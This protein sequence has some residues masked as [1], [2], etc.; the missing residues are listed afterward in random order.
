LIDEPVSKS[1]NSVTRGRVELKDL[2]VQRVCIGFRSVV[3]RNGG[4]TRR[5]RTSGVQEVDVQ[6]TISESQ[7]RAG[8][9]R[10]VGFLNREHRVRVIDHES[11]NDRAGENARV[12]R[13]VVHELHNARAVGV[14]DAPENANAGVACSADFE[15]AAGADGYRV[16]AKDCG[17]V[18]GDNLIRIRRAGPCR[19]VKL[20]DGNETVRRICSV[21]HTKSPC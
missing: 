8:S 15:V 3:D 18:G 16:A 7:R 20:L 5:S 11:F 2:A 10:T 9:A 12:A 6:A 1:A 17:R 13:P 4:L 21:R 14:L 19:T